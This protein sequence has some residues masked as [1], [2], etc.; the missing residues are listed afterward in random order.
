MG[1]W[2]NINKLIIKTLIV[3]GFSNIAEVF[4]QQNNIIHPTAEL[5]KEYIASIL[6]KN[7][8]LSELNLVK[9]TDKIIDSL[10]ILDIKGKIIYNE[11]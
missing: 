10:S 6:K 11:Q 3:L 4:M 5:S 1:S 9:V 7:I 2:E 8:S